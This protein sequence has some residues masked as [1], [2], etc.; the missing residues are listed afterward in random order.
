MDPKDA[1]IL[2]AGESNFALILMD[3]GWVGSFP[4]DHSSTDSTPWYIFLVLV[5][6][7]HNVSRSCTSQ[8]IAVTKYR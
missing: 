3:D 7:R 8:K 5:D 1:L 4:R 2:L 6:R